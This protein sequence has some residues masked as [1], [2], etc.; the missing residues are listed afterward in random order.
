MEN[1]KQGRS[2]NYVCYLPL[3]T[4]IRDFNE[5]KIE[6]AYTLGGMNYFSGNTNPR[7]YKIYFKPVSRNGGFESSIMMGSGKES[8]Y[9]I[10]IE[11]ANKYSAKR[12]LELAEKFDS[13]VGE[14][15]DCFETE[16]KKWRKSV[17]I[18]IGVM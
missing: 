12:L 2:R 10:S 14:L 1:F 11:E 9:Y 13:L 7:G 4:T 16:E 5:L 6:V 15:A 3:K 17:K 18:K 8:G